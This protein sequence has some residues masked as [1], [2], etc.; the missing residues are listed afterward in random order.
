MQGDDVQMTQDAT[1]QGQASK[2]PW[3]VDQYTLRLIG[4]LTRLIAGMNDCA[5]ELHLPVLIL[6]G[7]RDEL[8]Q[9]RD[10]RGF[11]AR[12][13][14]DTPVT[15]HHYDKAYH[16]LMHDRVRKQVF[17]DVAQWTDGLRAPE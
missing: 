1:H 4:N 5:K 8:N 10:I 9:D 2:N 15:Y 16:L 11:I 13:P 3:H 14:E 6:H 7:G 12:L 17:R